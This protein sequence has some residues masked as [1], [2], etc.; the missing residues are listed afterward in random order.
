MNPFLRLY[1]TSSSA[2][3]NPLCTSKSVLK[4]VA[5]YKQS[6][7]MMTN[8]AMMTND[9]YSSIQ[10]QQQQLRTFHTS[11][12]LEG[13]H[14]NNS[15]PL[16]NTNRS[17][18]SKSSKKSST[19]TT[20]TPSSSSSSLSNQG[21]NSSSTANHT[22]H[23]T[24]AKS[25]YTSQTRK[26]SQRQIEKEQ[27][28]V[29]N[30]SF[31]NYT[32]PPIDKK[33]TFSK[34]Q[35][36]EFKLESTLEQNLN[37]TFAGK[38]Q[39]VGNL[40][41]NINDGRGGLSKLTGFVPRDSNISSFIKS[42]SSHR[43]LTEKEINE[44][45]SRDH[46]DEFLQVLSRH[47]L[48]PM[49]ERK[50]LTTSPYSI[51]GTDEIL[52]MTRL[53]DDKHLIQN[54]E[55][56]LGNDHPQDQQDHHQRQYFHQKDYQQRQDHPQDQ[57]HPPSVMKTR[58]YSHLER[59][60]LNPND[61]DKMFDLQESK[62]HC[63]HLN[64]LAS[65]ISLSTSS[66]QQ[67]HQQ[68]LQHIQQYFDSIPFPNTFHYNILMSIYAR[69]AH[70]DRVE[71]IF[72]N[73]PYKNTTSYNIMLDVYLKQERFS[74][75]QHLF[76]QIPRHD[77]ESWNILME[78]FEK[79][80]E[81]E[82][83][84]QVF[85]LIEEPSIDNYNT[86]M[87]IFYRAK[88][89][90]TVK[91]IYEL[92]KNIMNQEEEWNK[93]TNRNQEEEWNKSMNR[94]QEEWNKSMNRN[95]EEE[96]N[97]STNRN[98]ILARNECHHTHDDSLSPNLLTFEI[99]INLS[100]DTK[101][102]EQVHEYIQQATRLNM[103]CERFFS[104]S[105][106]SK[107]EL[108]RKNHYIPPKKYYTSRSHYITTNS[109]TTNPNYNNT[110]YN[111]INNN[112]TIGNTLNN[113]LEHSNNHMNSF[114]YIAEM[115]RLIEEN[116]LDQMEQVLYHIP[117][118]LLT[119]EHFSCA[120]K[121]YS[122]AGNFNKTKQIFYDLIQFERA[123]SSILHTRNNSNNDNTNN[124][125]NNNSNNERTNETHTLVKESTTTSNKNYYF[126]LSCF[127]RHAE[128]TNTS[129][130]VIRMQ[131]VFNSI[132]HP[133]PS[134]YSILMLGYLKKKMYEKVEELFHEAMNKFSLNDMNSTIGNSGSIGSIGS[135]SSI[136]SSSSIGNSLNHSIPSSPRS[137]PPPFLD[138]HM[139]SIMI[140]CYGDQHK[141]DQ[142]FNLFDNII[143][144]R[145]EHPSWK[146]ESL[147]NGTFNNHNS[148]YNN[149]HNSNYNSMMTLSRS[150]DR[151]I[152]STDDM[153][154]MSEPD[155][156]MT[157]APQPSSLDHDSCSQLGL[158]PRKL[159]L[160]MMFTCAWKGLVDKVEEL[161]NKI[162]KY[163]AN[164]TFEKNVLKNG[165]A[166]HTTQEW[167]ALLLSHSIAR[168]VS[169]VEEVFK[170]IPQPDPFTY[171]I[172]ETSLEKKNKSYQKEEPILVEDDASLRDDTLSRQG[173]NSSNRRRSSRK[174]STHLVERVQS[175]MKKDKDSNGT[176]MLHVPFD[177]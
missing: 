77:D 12:S 50:P 139:Y 34:S 168:N 121:G 109:N 87:A 27:K 84:K 172:L 11:Q 112:N 166:I 33:I 138:M 2:C 94:N 115:E 53:I 69:H 22:N 8:G 110:N 140:R 92:L 146:E 70:Y 169:R 3:L 25:I 173:R 5:S 82:K 89:L 58:N 24:F 176:I 120:L 125:T 54:D 35:L 150:K 130:N 153:D 41:G 145:Y 23:D 32:P 96:W 17:R 31:L 36:Q 42:D 52:E 90:D 30:S 21:M 144:K 62:K 37:S 157:R 78:M 143:V 46:D 98:P 148:D 100:M 129:P 156:V 102:Y 91:Q 113:N 151:F 101:E 118:D 158:V 119:S 18:T 7:M 114:Q 81:I 13:R 49:N 126:Y 65:T 136:G 122:Q 6:P 159:N 71:E 86:L 16:S 40:F 141:F 155:I 56:K 174:S 28:I 45:T 97:K 177:G 171:K 29:S 59:T 66:Q 73:L 19:T 175:L 104:P 170:Q 147:Y 79:K 1:H 61:Y 167:N 14:R 103:N 76:Q 85:K 154:R 60:T 88:R 67:D 63:V 10:Q 64:K 51:G 164:T 20:K 124:N 111:N 165:E 47:K 116:Q 75:M 137:L 135:N 15:V 99:L 149:N 72:L 80:K 106:L 117:R 152:I 95:Q 38:K 127:V 132:P 83:V 55:Q 9:S 162:P 57:Q 26:L 93:S 39:T 123:Q 131:Q 43:R 105:T 44:I 107:I 108:L 4:H 163:Y 68:Q 134:L 48:E 161:F 128:L 160:V 133:N 74:E 142:L